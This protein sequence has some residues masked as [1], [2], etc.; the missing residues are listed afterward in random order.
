M[1]KKTIYHNVIASIINFSFLFLTSFA[2]I[3]F[4]FNYITL[5]D[6]GIWL[7]GISFLSLASILESNIGMILT[8]EL[9]K[10][11]S[12]KKIDKFSKYFT[13]TLLFGIIISILIIFTTYIIK[14]NIYEYITHKKNI[15][16]YLTTSF[17]LYSIA[18]CF[19]I[20]TSFITSINQVFSKTFLP[21]IFNI[22]ST[23]IGIYFTIKYIPN[24]GVFSIAIGNLI[25]AFIYLV[26]NI[27]YVYFILNTHKIKLIYDFIYLKNIFSSIAL[28][29]ISK[30]FMTSASSLQNFIVSITISSLATT[31]FDITKKIPFLV[32]LI[33][34]MFSAALFTYFSSFYVRNKDK[35]LQKKYTRYFFT[36]FNLMLL[37][38]LII[39]FLFGDKLISIW[40]GE[41]K[42]GGNLL[43]SILCIMAFT[44][45]LRIT[46]A[47]QYYAIAK[48]KFTALTDMIYGV[49]FLIFAYF[50]IPEFK[51]YGI[52]LSSILANLFYFISVKY[53]E[54]KYNIYMF[55]LLFNTS[56]LFDTI[57]LLTFALILKFILLLEINIFILIIL[58]LILLIF[59]SQIFFI[60]HKPVFLYLK[61]F[62][63]PNNYDK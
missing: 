40:V 52:V 12:E 44:D 7:S 54:I 45:Q 21:P 10:N 49:F 25:R 38:S 55:D 36:I 2:L 39:V 63:K 27:V 9:I 26:L 23:S 17:F 58:Y 15:N 57:F 24:Y 29:F 62:F 34:N 14:N 11:W 22:F 13:A 19:G 32:I 48:Y 53:L 46:L 56:F 50:L 60:K 33:L 51:L 42:F 31:I 30:L 8:Q 35:E 47:Q 61:Y 59:I 43:L 3:P 41:D 28:P 20:L 16:Q 1:K 37:F 5:S 18:L 4:Y 6:Y